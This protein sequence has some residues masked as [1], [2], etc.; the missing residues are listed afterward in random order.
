MAKKKEEKEKESFDIKEE[1][2]KINEYMR[3]GFHKYILDKGVKTKEEFE[4]LLKEYG[5]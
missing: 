2:E 1:L 5:G 3:E 4:E